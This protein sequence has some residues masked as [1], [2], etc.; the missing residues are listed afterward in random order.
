[1][2]SPNT[3]L[4]EDQLPSYILYEAIQELK[5]PLTRLFNHCLI[6]RYCPIHFRRSIIVALRK[7]KKGDFKNPKIYRPIALLNTVEKIM[8]K[9]LIK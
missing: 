4:G 3:V 8:D 1:M 5:E 2:T 9:V 7:L 6:A